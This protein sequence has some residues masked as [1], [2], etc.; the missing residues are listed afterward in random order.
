MKYKISG[1]FTAMVETEDARNAQEK[2]L[3]RARDGDVQ[4]CIIDVEEATEWKK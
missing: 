3:K 4:A 1:I 2:M